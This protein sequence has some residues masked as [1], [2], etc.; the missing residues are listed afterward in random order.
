MDLTADSTEIKRI[1]RESCEQFCA[2]KLDN[3][4]EIDKFLETQNLPKLN[5]KE[6]E[7]PNRPNKEIESITK[8]LPTQKSP[9]PDGLTGEFYQIFEER[10]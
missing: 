6:I 5:H 7:N 2:N 4:D 1:R 9:G 10:M 8:N 3:L